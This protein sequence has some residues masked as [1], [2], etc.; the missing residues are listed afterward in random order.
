MVGKSRAELA[1]QVLYRDADHVSPAGAS[2]LKPMLDSVFQ[3]VRERIAKTSPEVVI[4][5]R[6]P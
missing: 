5:P 2:L 6:T 3:H 4:G 1:G